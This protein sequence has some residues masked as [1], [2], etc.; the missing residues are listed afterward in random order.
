MLA[1]RHGLGMCSAPG[2][3]RPPMLSHGAWGSVL[4]GEVDSRSTWQ[5][6]LQQGLLGDQFAG[7]PGGATLP[8]GPQGPQAPQKR[9]RRARCS[10][11]ALSVGSRV[12]AHGEKDLV[13]LAAG[14]T[15]GPAGVLVPQRKGPG[16]LWGS[17]SRV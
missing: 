14:E 3:H 6:Q 8:T 15:K 9:P 7:P 4:A 16:T 1:F 11:K 17:R 13:E 2:P 10:G 12:R 5:V